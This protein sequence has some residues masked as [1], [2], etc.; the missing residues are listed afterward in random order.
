MEELKNEEQYMQL[1]IVQINLKL[2][3]FLRNNLLN[4]SL[5]QPNTVSD[6]ADQL[7]P[8]NKRV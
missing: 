6:L 5:T 1:N 7:I 4:N 3:F 8:L 2:K